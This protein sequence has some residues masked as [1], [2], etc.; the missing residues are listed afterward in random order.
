E[1]VHSGGGAQGQRT[2]AQGRSSASC[3]S[4]SA[5]SRGASSAASGR[6]GCAAPRRSIGA[7]G[8]GPVGTSSAGQEAAATGGDRSHIRSNGH[9]RH[10]ENLRR[11]W[12]RQVDGLADENEAARFFRQNKILDRV[13]FEIGHKGEPR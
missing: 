8:R 2:G 3:A 12:P 13:V 9:R 7:A 10:F 4:S 1:F 11:R 5:S 6:S